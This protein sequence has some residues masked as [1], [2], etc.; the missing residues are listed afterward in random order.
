M[1]A[2]FS[3]QQPASELWGK[4]VVF[5]RG[6]TYLLEA[7]SGTGKSSL[8]A[9]VY[10]YRHDYSGRIMFDN[11]VASSLGSN[12]WRQLRLTSV[13]LLFQEL[14][15]FDELTA[16][17]NVKLKNDLTG[18]KSAD[19]LRNLFE[20]LGIGDK[21]DTLA[22]L[23]SF[24]QRQRVAFIRALCQPFD[25]ILLDEPVSHLDESNA[26]TLAT[27][28]TDEV[29]ERGAAAIVTSVGQR[30]MIDYDKKIAL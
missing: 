23:M 19:E 9:Y 15:L 16:W 27:L 12:A 10:G 24:G 8:C 30:L 5:E 2:A 11:K 4:S 17:E 26:A 7:A 13:S 3:R 21:T 18:Y 14:R 29:R 20:V 6:K 28:L 25:F 1:P 22:R